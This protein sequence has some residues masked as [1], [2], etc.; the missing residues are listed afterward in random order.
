MYERYYGLRERPFSLTS[1]PRYYLLVTAAHA[2]ALSTLR[3]GIRHRAGIIV[4]I[5]EAGTGKTT[6]VRAAMGSR[7]AAG[8]FVLLNNPLLAR[9]E[10]FEHLVRG[11]GLS[12][13]AASSKT[14]FLAE[15]ARKLKAIVRGGSQAALVVDEAHALQPE[16]LEEIRLLSNIETDDE[17]LLSIVLAGQPELGDY[18]NTTS[19]RQLKQR[20]A[21]RTSL[22]PLQIT[23]T[24]AYIAGRIRVAGGDAATVFTSAAVELVHERSLGV[25]RTINVICDN[26]LLT[27]FGTDQ[28]PVGRETV[29]EVCRDLDLPSPQ[30]VAVPPPANHADPLVRKRSRFFS[31]SRQTT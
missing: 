16:I 5:G 28:R 11:F 17:K 24:A 29:L 31:W 25:P 1:N 21:L 7:A 30:P 26:A 9:T 2:E 8:P 12:Q 4:L 22:C 19:L 23:E 14:R 6:V 13:E 10:F 18:L 15:L 27:G 3:Y 20:V